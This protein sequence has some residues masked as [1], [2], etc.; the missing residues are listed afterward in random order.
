MSLNVATR[1]AA[2]A[3]TAH[4]PG[5]AIGAAPP[6]KRPA[7]E[8][9]RTGQAATPHRCLT[10]PGRSPTNTGRARVETASPGRHGPTARRPPCPGRH[11]PVRPTPL[12]LLPLGVRA[13]TGAPAP[14]RG[15]AR[16][17]KRAGLDTGKAYSAVRYTE[18][19][20]GSRALS[21]RYRL[22]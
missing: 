3:P 14:Q 13:G 21:A 7:R 11:A 19:A 1:D 18:A 6:D 12:F 2:A 22:A 10:R 9:A 15:A 20:S 16:P 4:K 17:A 8:G 5:H